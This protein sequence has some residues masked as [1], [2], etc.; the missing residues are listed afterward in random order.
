MKIIWDV[1]LLPTSCKR[2]KHKLLS[3]KKMLPQDT[4]QVS[5]FLKFK[6]MMSI[7]HYFSMLQIQYVHI[8]H[9]HLSVTNKSSDLNQEKFL[10]SFISHY[11]ESLF[12]L[13]CLIPNRIRFILV[14]RFFFFLFSLSIAGKWLLMLCSEFAFVSSSFVVSCY[15]SSYKEMQDSW[16]NW[17]KANAIYNVQCSM[18]RGFFS[19]V[20]MYTYILMP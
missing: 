19:S 15:T 18:I 2:F 4:C 3:L 8:I 5:A 11:F 6:S 16:W 17:V 14:F 1:R 9:M 10:D 7:K 13:F 20:Q 12:L